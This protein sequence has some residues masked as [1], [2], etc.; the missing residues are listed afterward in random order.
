MAGF[1]A[2]AEREGFVLAVPDAIDGVWNDG[3]FPDTDPHRRPDDVGYLTAL[4]DDVMA[5]T[6]VD[7]RRVYVF[8]MSNATRVIWDFLAAHTRYRRERRRRAWM[9]PPGTKKPPVDRGLRSR[10]RCGPRRAT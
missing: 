8:G 7:A 4:V 10:G 3:R 5:H 1:V 6:P 2:R 9:T